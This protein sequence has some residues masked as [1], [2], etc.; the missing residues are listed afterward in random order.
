MVRELRV[1][2]LH[3]IGVCVLGIFGV[4]VLGVHG[5]RAFLAFVKV[6]TVS[7]KCL[8]LLCLDVVA[9]LCVSQLCYDCWFP[10]SILL[11]GNG[12][13]CLQEGG[14]VVLQICCSTPAGGVGIPLFSRVQLPGVPLVAAAAL[15]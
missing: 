3:V 2:G 1:L 14:R 7:S 9:S 4:C 6:Q 8:S 15:Q 10:G 11:V 12:Q 5:V 13:V